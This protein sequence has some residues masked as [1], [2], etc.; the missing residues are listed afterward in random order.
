MKLR[1]Q[2]NSLLFR[3]TPRE[4]A[5]LVET[6]RIEET[7]YF[8]SNEQ[9]KLIYAIEYADLSS[10][11]LLYQS[12]EILILLPAEELDGWIRSGQ[13]MLYA[14]IE[15]GTCGAIDVFIE[16]DCELLDTDVVLAPNGHGG[17]RPF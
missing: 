8:A 3:V 17:T 7:V 11:A 12:P 9:S 14:T 1:V 5:E 6:G 4:L 15:L 10:A 13:T 2:G 16:R